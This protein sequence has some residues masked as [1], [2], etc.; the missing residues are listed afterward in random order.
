MVFIYYAHVGHKCVAEVSNEIFFNRYVCIKQHDYKDCG[1]TCFANIYKQYDLRYPILKTREVA[2]TDK[3]STSIVGV[4][5]VEKE[6][7][8]I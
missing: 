4:I 7:L 3:E 1:A 2:G 8:R 5:K 6:V